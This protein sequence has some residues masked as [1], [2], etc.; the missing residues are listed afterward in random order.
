[1]EQKPLISVIVPVYN[2]L[3][4]LPRCVRSITAQTWQNLEVLLVDDGSTDG[5]GALCDELA[6]EDKR[7]RVFHKENGG[8]SSARNLA[9]EK[10][11]G[12][13]L[14]FVDSDDYIAPKSLSGFAETIEGYASENNGV[15]ALGYCYS[16]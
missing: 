2:I 13:Y 7:I 3:Q 5:T 10:S 14:G 9:L 15:F 1:M 16:R 12:D 4:Y 11:R 8:S 6:G